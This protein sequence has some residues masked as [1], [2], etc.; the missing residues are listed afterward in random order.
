[1]HADTLYHRMLAQEK[2]IEAAKV[3]GL[4]EPSFAPL[5]NPAKP[6]NPLPQPGSEPVKEEITLET[7]K[8]SLQAS[9][10]KRLEGLS[11]QEKVLEE[12][13][14]NAELQAAAQT[15]RKINTLWDE[16]EAERI[17]RKEAGKETIMDRVTTLLRWS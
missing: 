12:A 8:A 1:M 14:I 3:A 17:K 13:A 16:R 9:F 5:L 2:E 10:K 11:A 4:P 6:R 7:A 15:N